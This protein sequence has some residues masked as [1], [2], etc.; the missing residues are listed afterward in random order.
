MEYCEVKTVLNIMSQIQGSKYM[1][2]QIFSIHKN[3]QNT[4]QY[5]KP[6]LFVKG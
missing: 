1:V 2:I 5:Y 6:N 4:H 3:T